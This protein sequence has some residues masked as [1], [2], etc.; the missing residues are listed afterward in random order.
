M[1]IR[2]YQP[3]DFS[4][5]LEL[6][7]RTHHLDT[8]TESILR[9]KLEGDPGF[10]PE[11]TYVAVVD[12][13]IAGFL[14]GVV[15]DIR[16]EQ[17]AYIKLMGV[18]QEYRRQGIARAMYHQMEA[19]AIQCGSSTIR[20][21]DV[22]LN[23]LVPG[24]DPRYTPALCFAERMGFRRFT[25]TSNLLAP[26]NRNW[27]TSEHEEK[28]N[29]RGIKICRA[30]DDY[31]E[32][33]MDFIDANFSLWRHEVTKAFE[34][35]PVSIHIAVENETVQAFSAHSANNTG[36]GW[37]GP[38]GTHPGMRGKG[39]GSILLKRCM[40]DLNKAGFKDAIIPWVGP[41]AFYSHHCGA[42]VDRVFWRYEKRPKG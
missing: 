16:G 20:I 35:D 21:Y 28:L 42:V 7:V 18:L 11:M 1:I 6:M 38:M 8:I 4:S 36:T 3:Q 26:L 40:D 29:T 17:I 25:D 33:L 27:D 10:K 22:A 23:Y 19:E 41:I 24:I 13:V 37:F 32:S 12:D 31:R 5:V 15:R 14:Q 30:G 34:N 39:V 2:L 9:E